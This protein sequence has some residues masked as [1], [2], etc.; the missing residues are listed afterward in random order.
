MS[1]LSGLNDD[2]KAIDT[3]DYI[4]AN[5]KLGRRPVSTI[6]YQSEYKPKLDKL[7]KQ[8]SNAQIE[9]GIVSGSI[10]NLDKKLSNIQSILNP[11][12]SKLENGLTTNVAN[13]KDI[14]ENTKKLQKHIA[15]I[16]SNIYVMNQK[17]SKLGTTITSK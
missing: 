14:I 4:N 3:N 9:I 15:I 10:S 5:A 7:N 8:I 17:L 6:V 13:Y 12:I 11:T 16:R 2:V 1:K